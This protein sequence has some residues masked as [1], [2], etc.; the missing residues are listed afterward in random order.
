MEWIRRN[1]KASVAL[2]AIATLTVV[3]LV[4]VLGRSTPASSDK[5]TTLALPSPTS[6]RAPLRLPLASSASAAPTTGASGQPLGGKAGSV[7][8]SMMHLKGIQGGSIDQ[9]LPRHQLVLEATSED[10][11]GT[12][13]YIVP[14]SLRENYGLV[15]NVGRTWRLTTTVYGDPDYAQLFLQAGYRGFPIT[16]TI[17]V[18]GRVTERR[19]TEGPYGQ[20][21]CQG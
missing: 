10:K 6:T 19:S 17:T 11:I 3:S 12:V 15:K 7:E 1:P 14:T 18:D 21:M 2:V 4:W 8:A 13:G 20:L 16:C 5:A 9:T